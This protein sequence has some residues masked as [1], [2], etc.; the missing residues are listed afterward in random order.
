MRSFIFVLLLFAES[1][2]Q[3]QIKEYTERIDIPYKSK[4]LTEKNLKQVRSIWERL[5]KNSTVELILIAEKEIR[6]LDPLA[7][8]SLSM[9]RAESIKLFLTSQKIAHAADIMFNTTSWIEEEG[10]YGTKTSFKRIVR[11]PYKVYSVIL[12]KE[13][14]ACY[15]YTPAELRALSSKDPSVFTINTSQDATITGPGGVIVY[16]PAHSFLLPNGKLTADIQVQ[17]WEFLK[18]SEMI[19]AGLY[20]SSTGKMLETGGMIYIRASCENQCLKLLRSSKIL[21]KFPLMY[22]EKQSGMYNFKGVPLTDII[23]WKQTEYANQDTVPPVE[24]EM[25]RDS[26][27]NPAFYVFESNGLGWINCDRFYNVEDKIDVR[28]TSEGNL[29]F[30]ASLVFSDI[31]SIMP[32]DFIPTQKNNVIFHNVPRG[33]EVTL[34]IYG[35]DPKK[36]TVHYYIEPVKLQET[37]STAAKLKEVTLDEFKL[38]VKG[39][40]G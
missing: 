37:I 23:D 27:G 5:P 40:K 14:P 6:K 8:V 22:Y 35:Y 21:V 1:V 15:D 30:E 7:L 31:N 26:A 16:I 32:G 36:K 11:N 34:L 9:S 39:L 29:N 38:V 25:E 33:A 13:V 4:A 2:V 18:T 12:S 24:W 28:V 20:T 3:A 19:M 17:L 10:I